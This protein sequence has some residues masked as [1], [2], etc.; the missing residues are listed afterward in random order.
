M[1]F[2]RIVLVAGIAVSLSGTFVSSLCREGFAPWA[3]GTCTPKPKATIGR[4]ELSSLT[5]AEQLQLRLV[6]QQLMARDDNV[7]T[8]GNDCTFFN[9]AKHHGYFS[10]LSQHET[11]TCYQKR[12]LPWHRLYMYEIEQ[13]GQ[14]VYPGFALPYWDFTKVFAADQKTPVLDVLPKL[15]TNAT[16]YNPNT[17]KEEPNPLY[18]GYRVPTVSGLAYKPDPNNNITRSDGTENGIL[19]CVRQ[20]VCLVFQNYDTYDD[21]SRYIECPHNQIHNFVGGMF[22]YS[23]TNQ[24]WTGFDPLFY[25]FHSMIDRLWAIWERRNP[26]GDD[27][28]T[29]IADST[30]FSPWG[31]QWTFADTKDYEQKMGYSYDDLPLTF[32]FCNDAPAVGSYAMYGHFTQL[33]LSFDRGYT[34]RLIADIDAIT[35]MGQVGFLNNSDVLGQVAIPHAMGE[36]NAVTKTFERNKCTSPT[37]HSWCPSCNALLIPRNKIGLYNKTFDLIRSDQLFVEFRQAGTSPIDLSANIPVD[38]FTQKFIQSILANAANFRNFPGT[39]QPPIQITA[40]TVTAGPIKCVRNAAAKIITV[41]WTFQ[42][43]NYAHYPDCIAQPGDLL[44]FNYYVPE[45]SVANVFADEFAECPN[46]IIPICPSYSDQPTG[47]STCNFTIP[48]APADATYYFMCTQSDHCAVRG[49]RMRVVVGNGNPYDCLK[50]ES[51]E[52]MPNTCPSAGI[53]ITNGT[54]VIRKPANEQSEGQQPPYNYGTS[55]RFSCNTPYKLN[56]FPV[57]HCLQNGQWSSPF[58]TCEFLCK[59]FCKASE[60]IIR[61]GNAD[62]TSPLR[63]SSSYYC[64]QTSATFTCDLGYEIIGEKSVN[65]SNDGK[66]F[67]EIENPKCKKCC[68]ESELK[69]EHG[70]ASSYFCSNTTSATFTCDAGY[71]LV[72]KATVI[73]SNDGKWSPEI[74]KPKCKGFINEPLMLCLVFAM[75]VVIFR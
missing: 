33:P 17:N 34:V 66:W 68:D 35:G 43:P 57:L 67:P 1:L 23:M 39:Q 8:Q 4:K 75:F 70:N 58:P 10:S 61:N 72:G 51:G 65:C 60:L 21:F 12:F 53:N 62:I 22:D 40:G 31:D 2:H 54:T 46:F 44:V 3:N 13:A 29:A 42:S 59:D 37:C 30:T 27:T 7:T 26:D 28:S 18:S 69:I 55:V 63:T 32:D 24:R 14:T 73:C 45:H 5:E 6:F 41:D 52:I 38:T 36:Y 74:E 56:G 25:V 19:D 16:F 15:F 47:L 48:T 11:T 20:Q 49:M 64:N 71:P 9:I 50:V